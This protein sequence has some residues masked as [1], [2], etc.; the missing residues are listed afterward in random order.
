[1]KFVFLC[2]LCRRHGGCPLAA[3]VVPLRGTEEH[4]ERR[5][6]KPLP[7]QGANKIPVIKGRT[8]MCFMR[9]EEGGKNGQWSPTVCQ[10]RENF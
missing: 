6:K 5:P 4:E 9:R 1:M 2:H 7:Q 3:A 10:G 8:L